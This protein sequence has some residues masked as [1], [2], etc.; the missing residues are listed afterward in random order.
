[1][2][3]VSDQP[4]GE[5][6]MLSDCHSAAL[7]DRMGSIE[8]WCAPRFDSPSVFGRILDPDAGHFSITARDARRVQRR[9]LAGSLVLETTITTDSGR[10]VLTDALA[11]GEGVR[12]HDLG[13]DSPHVLMRLVECVEGDVEIDVEFV[14]RFEYGLTRPLV[15]PVEG[16]VAAKGGPVT[17]LLATSLPLEVVGPSATRSTGLETGDRIGFA[18]Q[19]ASSWDPLPAAWTE[20]HV[21]HRLADTQEAWQTWGESHHNYE[22]P[23]EDLVAH[24]GRVLQGLTYR[25]TGAMVAA[26]TTSLPE[27]IGGER[28]WDYRY[29]WVRDAGFTLRA[30][31][32]AACPDEAGTYLDYLTAASSSV[33]E[34]DH[35][36]IMFG[37]R[38]GRDLSERTL[39]WL[40]GW[41]N[42]APVRVGND[43]WRQ[44]QHDVYGEILSAMHR[45][46]E[47]VGDLDQTEQRLLRLLADRAA[48]VWREPDAGIWE[49]R[50]PAQHHVHSKLMCWVALDRAI[51]LAPQLDAHEHV[52]AWRSAAADIRDAILEHGWSD[53]IGSFTQAF[54]VPALDASSLVIPIVGFLPFDD[55]RVLATVETIQR[56]LVD[57]LG[58]VHRYRAD[59]GLAGDEGSFLL[60]TFWLVEALAGAGRVD[61][62]HSVFQTAIAYQND[63]GL[64]AEEVATTGE[65]VG[66][67]PQAFSH[68][69][70]VNGAWAIAQAE[71]RG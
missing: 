15:S 31:W 66:N 5:H 24:S 21:R 71:T 52:E 18:V 12:H 34:R 29:C 10:L 56:E 53:E 23:Y 43:A 25:P 9:Y 46:R 41:R 61:E 26:P 14:P 42:S 64:L 57:S 35:L 69:G 58:L 65:L 2:V 39:P 50:G 44:T 6:A 1:M 30:L 36:Q 32:V 22:G 28:N 37:I 68:V 47:Q 7:V 19:M 45:L 3:R 49:I 60:C 27:D 13:L 67:Y 62:A 55:E 4:I 63:V 70:L 17:L 16:G 11:M 51:D 20:N 38:G 33:Y 8:W 48:V 40:R 54:G 59:D